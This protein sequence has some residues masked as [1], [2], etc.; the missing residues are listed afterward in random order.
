MSN[1][2]KTEL[3]IFIKMPTIEVIECCGIVGMDFVVIDMEHTPL[4]PRD[5]YP[6][7][8]A[9]EVRKLKVIVRLP[10]LKEEYFKWCLDLGI[11][12]L[13]VP[14]IETLD[15]VAQVIDNSY[16]SP[17][18]QRGLCR[19]V[20]AADFSNM[21]KDKYIKESNENIELIFQIEG[22]EG[23][24]NIEQIINHENVSSIFI[25]P[26]DLSQS[27]GFPGDIWNDNVIDKIKKIIEKCKTNSISVGIFTDT[28]K[29]IKFWT[30]LGVDFIEYSSDMML[31][32]EALKKLKSYED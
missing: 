19:F 6:L 28:I 29:G 9:S 12:Y 3:G 4:S 23:F 18:G 15:D 5:L 21:D 22:I 2:S 30:N 24:N 20:R 13:Q 17:L 7:V 25:G 31:I 32:S 10:N 14:H 1:K 11:K 26:Y 8:L 16:F 27:L